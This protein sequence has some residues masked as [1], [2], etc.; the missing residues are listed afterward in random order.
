LLELRVRG[1]IELEKPLNSSAPLTDSCH[2]RLYSWRDWSSLAGNWAQLFE[3]SGASFFLHPDWVQ[4]WLHTFGEELNPGVFA[5]DSGGTWVGAGLM[6]SSVYWLKFVRLRRIYLNCAGESERDSTVIEYNRLMCLPGCERLVSRS[7]RNLLRKRTWDELALCG[8]EP[9]EGIDCLWDGAL[10]LQSSAEPSPF[11]DLASLRSR[12]QNY[13]SQLSPNTRQQI[14]RSVRFL[15][16][17]CG[18][19][20]IEEAATAAEALE[21]L[22]LLAELHQ[23][24]WLDRGKQGAFASQKFFAFHCRLI[25]QVFEKGL[26]HLLRATAGEE[27]F[28]V[29]YNFFFQ[30]RVYF[31]QSGFRYTRD[32]RA[33]PGLTTHFLAI[34]HYLRARNDA[35]EYDF[36][37]GDAYY[38]RSLCNQQRALTWFVVQAPTFP[39]R[40][41]KA[42]RDCKAA[43]KGRKQ[44][45]NPA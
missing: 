13:E 22:A 3:R 14:R 33:S 12:D 42:L 7:L 28:G 32:H 30:G 27:V 4:T 10:S 29:L 36:L 18:P 34:N 23:K 43:L 35:F 2:V 20:K 44:H 17:A 31:Y 45:G 39:S 5:I 19:V 41:V 16:Q 6:V 38:K 40:V 37:A 9:Q 25:S 21:Q 8:M 26:V 15:E 24:A 1:G 11:V